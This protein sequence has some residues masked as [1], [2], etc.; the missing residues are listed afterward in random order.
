MLFSKYICVYTSFYYDMFSYFCVS[1]KKTQSFQTS[2]SGVWNKQMTDYILIIMIILLHELFIVIAR[3]YFLCWILFFL[4]FLFFRF[5][6]IVLLL[7]L[8]IRNADDKNEHIS[9]YT[10]SNWTIDVYCIYAKKWRM[11]EKV[12]KTFVVRSVT[13]LSPVS[14][15]LS[16]KVC[17]LRKKKNMR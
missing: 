11:I 6:C 17:E 5:F 9:I 12:Q 7:L 1:F 8:L 3:F 2:M 10:F 16:L 14:S 15:F 13:C 4:S